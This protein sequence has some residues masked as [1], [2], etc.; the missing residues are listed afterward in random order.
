MNAV[1]NS[2]VANQLMFKSYYRGCKARLKADLEVKLL[3]NNDSR[4]LS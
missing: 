4:L 3:Q 1:K 2:S